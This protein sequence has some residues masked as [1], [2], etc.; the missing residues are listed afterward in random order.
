MDSRLLFT[1]L[2]VV[3]FL[4]LNAQSFSDCE[5][6]I[7]LEDHS[8]TIDKVTGHGDVLE[9]SGHELGNKMFF[10]EEHNTI[11]LNIPMKY[12]GEFTFTVT[13]KNAED[14]FDFMVFKGGTDVCGQIA[15]GNLKPVRSNLARND[16]TNGGRT[17]LNMMAESEFFAAGVNPNMSKW[18]DVNKE[19]VYTVVIDINAEE[20]NGF[21]FRWNLNK[22]EEDIH[23]E[24]NHNDASAFA[25]VDMTEESGDD[26]MIEIE[27][28][29]LHE[30]S[31][32]PVECHAEIIGVQWSD[33]ELKFDG[34]SKFT[35]SIPEGKWFFVNVKKDGYTFGTEKYKATEDLAQSPHKIFITEVKAGEHIVLKEIVFRENTTHLLPS[36]INALEQLINFMNDY[37]NAKIEVQGHV[38]AP[39]YDNDGKVKKFSLKRAEQIKSYLVDAG[40]EGK[41]IEVRGMGNEFMIYPTPTNYDE[42]KANRRVE[43]EILSY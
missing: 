20:N 8:I 24:E 1:I 10:T 32:I 43:I 30:G 14:D 42:E 17:G 15:S 22:T 21:E 23:I 35:A 34:V 39:G 25:F 37:P 19:E 41:R 5:S 33:E 18:I 31:E 2:F 28:E 26:G 4:S 13:P 9:I 29:V 11:W 6:S 7:T 36:S 40:I 38:N 27:F 3:S 16:K 12:K